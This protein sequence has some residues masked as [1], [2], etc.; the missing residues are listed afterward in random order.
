MEEPAPLYPYALKRL[1]RHGPAIERLIGELRD[2]RGEFAGGDLH[3]ALGFDA[4]DLVWGAILSLGYE[5]RDGTREVR[6]RVAE[7]I[8]ETLRKMGVPNELPEQQGL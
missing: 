8:I 6:N 4:A 7:A 1:V 5:H 2:Q 3:H